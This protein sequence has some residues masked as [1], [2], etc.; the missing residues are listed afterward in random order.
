M[1]RTESLVLELQRKALSNETKVSDLLRMA[2]VVAR[3]L[4][5]GEFEQW[6]NLELNGYNDEND[7]EIPQYRKFQAALKVWNPYRG[8]QPLFTADG[9]MHEELS[10]SAALQSIV[11]LESLLSD[12]ESSKFYAY[13][14]S[15]LER[16]LMD[17]MQIAMRPAREIPRSQIERVVDRVRNLVLD[18]SLRLEQAGVLGEGMTFSNE[19]KAKATEA[20]VTYNVENQTVIHGM[21]H[22]QIQQGTNHSNQTFSQQQTDLAAVA[23]FAAE[24]RKQIDTLGLPPDTRSEIDADLTTVEV[25][26][27]SPKPRVPIIKEALKSIRSV[28]ENAAGSATGAALPVLITEVA[29]LVN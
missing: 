20:T 21:T 9:E 27:R 28:L 17:N 18:W 13:F 2:L 24:L 3:K 1:S 4:D 16:H 15:D 29:K 12:K 22:S 23:S 5:I 19:E 11:E 8:W 7:D 10:R 25:Q 14:R 6:I 26:S